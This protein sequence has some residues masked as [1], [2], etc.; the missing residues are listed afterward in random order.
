MK[1]LAPFRNDDLDKGHFPKS[2]MASCP[3]QQKLSLN[4]GHPI[5]EDTFLGPKCS[6]SYIVYNL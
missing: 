5:N 6:L 4:K 3:L 2:K 1:L